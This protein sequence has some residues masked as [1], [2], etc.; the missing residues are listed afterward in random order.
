MVVGHRG[1]HTV[2]SFTPHCPRITRS[3]RSFVADAAVTRGPAQPVTA[4]AFCHQESRL[5]V[6]SGGSPLATSSSNASSA[7]IRVWDLTATP[8]PAPLQQFQGGHS[9]AVGSLAVLPGSSYAVSAGEYGAGTVEGQAGRAAVLCLWALASAATKKAKKTVEPE[10]PFRRLLRR[11]AGVEQGGGWG[12]MG[13][14]WM[15]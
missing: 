9:G 11:R 15:S 6:A 8:A 12:S 4:L 7:S 10:A 2:C 13:R 5:I 1:P 14:Q 3:Y